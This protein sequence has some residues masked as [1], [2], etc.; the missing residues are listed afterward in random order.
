MTGRQIPLFYCDH[1]HFSL[2]PGHKFP[3]AKYK[4]LREDLSGDSRFDIQ[5]SHLISKTDL[6]RIHTAT[7]VEQF[8]TGELDPRAMRRIGFPWSEGLAQR[9]LASAGSTLNAVQAALAGGVGGTLAGGTHHAFRSEGSG[10]C[11]FNDLAV[12]IEWARQVAGLRRV[13][14]IDLD[15]HQGDGTAA[16]FEGDPGIFTLSIHGA[17]NFPL[18]KQKGRLDIELPD[19]A[20][21]VVFLEALQT[22]LPSVWDFD[23]QLALF[24]SGVDGL[25]SDRLG[26]LALTINGLAQRDRLVLGGACERHIPL[27]VTLGGGYSE[28]IEHTVNAHAQTFRTVADIYYTGQNKE[29]GF[30]SGEIVSSSSG[31]L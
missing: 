18:R 11:V 13:A 7:Y 22:A 3:L 23:P 2:P 4:L 24:Q 9:T 16:I 31:T 5:P 30:R 8:L 20:P 19:A 27:A 17:K 10:F 25:S 14:V 15:V 6:L 28:P 12:S 1:H 26:R 29:T 21:D